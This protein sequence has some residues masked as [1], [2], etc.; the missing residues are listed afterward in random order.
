MSQQTIEQFLVGNKLYYLNP[1]Y[2]DHEYIILGYNNES[3]KFVINQYKKYTDV[4]KMNIEFSLHVIIDDIK[5]YNK[6]FSQN[7][8]IFIKMIKLFPEYMI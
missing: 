2:G 7:R 1:L 6:K 4:N 8:T 5:R 3:N